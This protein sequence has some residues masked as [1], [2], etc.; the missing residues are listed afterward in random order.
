LNQSISRQSRFELPLDRLQILAWLE[1]DGLS[2]RNGNFFTGPRIPT[3]SRFS[4]LDRENAKATQLNTIIFF[5]GCLHGFEN[6]ID[7]GF[8]LG[9]GNAG[10]LNNLVND[11]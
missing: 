11:V 8:S 1:A 6:G 9:S 7:G 3:D 5:Q 4:G 10:S 2:R